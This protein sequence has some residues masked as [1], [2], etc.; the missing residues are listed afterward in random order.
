MQTAHAQSLPYHPLFDESKV[1]SIYITMD[2]DS[3]NELYTDVESN[4]EYSV[5]FVYDQGA[6]ADTLENVGFRLRGN[7]SR[8]SAKKSFKVSFNTFEPGRKYEG[9]EKLNLNGS[10]NDPSMIRE[11]LYYDAWNRFGLTPRRSSFVMVYI[12]ESYYGLYTNIEEMDEIWCKDRFGDA[13]G[14]LYKCTYPAD[15]VYLGPD[16][17]DYK[18]DGSAS[19]GGRAYDL[20]N[21]KAADDYSDLVNLITILEASGD[22]TLRCELERVFNVD[23]FLRA[24]AMDVASG[25]WDDYAFN[26]NNFYLYHDPLTD[27]LEFIAYD[28]DNTFGVDWFGIDWTSRSVYAWHNETGRPLVSRILDIPEYNQLY[29]FYLEQ[30]LTTVLSPANIEPH[31]DSLKNLITAAALEDDYKE[32]DWGYSDADFLNSFN[33]NGVDGH[34]PYGVKNFIEARVTNASDEIEW[35]NVAPVITDHGH[36]PQIPDPGDPVNFTVIAFDDISVSDLKIFYSYNAQVF[37]ES[38]MYDDG[39]HNDAAAGDHLFGVQV[40]AATADGFVYFHFEA[41]DNAGASSRYPV[42]N[43][44][45]IKI[46]FEPP[47]IFIN[48][49]LASNSSVIADSYNEFDDYVEI[50]NAGT[51]PVYLGDKYLSDNRLNPSKWRLPAQSLNGD[52]YLLIWTDNDPEQ[53]PDHADFSLDATGEHI[54]LYASALEYFSAIDTTTFGQQVTDISIGRLPNGTGPFTV[55]PGPTPGYDNYAVTIMESE[56]I[57]DS[58]LVLSDPFSNGQYVQLTLHAA[59]G[60]VTLQLMSL[61]GMQLNKFFSGSL[62]KGIHQFPV[63]AEALPAGMYILKATLDG[64]LLVTRL[65]VQ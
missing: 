26:K 40:P 49:V 21:N 25:N 4:H 34:T 31:I 45:K 47:P 17:E 50:Y 32:L 46:G 3:L 35:V 11:K 33:T 41:V 9:Y 24:F 38:T 37:F 56:E 64:K 65:L 51:V 36:L 61:Q 55:L 42:C 29:S 39:M 19:S 48:E 30:L 18:Y 10:H 20:Q 59:A 5:R 7:S 28:C 44:F 16:Q 12:N 53:G 60:L 27:R 52:S 1:N 54:G 14:N 57:S 62:E 8:Y 22:E 6:L 2:E 58:V 43:E 13:S 15:L 23:A 63:P